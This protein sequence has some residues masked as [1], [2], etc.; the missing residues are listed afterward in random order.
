MTQVICFIYGINIIPSIYSLGF[1]KSK[2]RTEQLNDN[3]NNNNN[4]NNYNNKFLTLDQLP[5][6]LDYRKYNNNTINYAS[7]DRNEFQPYYCGACWAFAATSALSDRLKILRKNAF[8]EINLSPQVILNCDKVDLGCHGGDFGTAYEFIYQNGGIPDETCQIYEARGHDTGKSCNPIDKCRQC[9]DDNN[10]C[11]ARITYKKWQ[12]S[13]HGLVNGTLAMMNEIYRNGPIACAVAEVPDL[14]HYKGGIIH[15]KTGRTSLDHAISIVGW[16]ESAE[17]GT[18][19]W[20]VRNQWG[21][22]WGENGYARI[23]RGINNIGIESDCA[24]AIPIT[25]PV[26]VVVNASDDNKMN[27][28]KSSTITPPSSTTSCRVP[29]KNKTLWMKYIFSDENNIKKK[30]KKT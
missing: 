9:D 7:I 6:Q 17:D 29:S 12:I 28:I 16:G 13:S 19:Y 8:P 21:T 5:K 22:W 10:I 27:V 25:K 4:N 18:K 14:M 24:W 1:I 11:K 30:K 23:I 15:D 2:Y 20:I 3:N 26:V